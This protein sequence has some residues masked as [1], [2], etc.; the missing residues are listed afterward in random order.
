MQVDQISQLMQ[1]SALQNQTNS[2]ENSSAADSFFSNMFENLIQNIANGQTASTNTN[3]S[4]GVNKTSGI[5]SLSMKA[6]SLQ[7]MLQL[8]ALQSMSSTCDNIGDAYD[9]SDDGTDNSGDSGNL[10][11]SDILQS[12]SGDSSTTNQ[13]GSILDNFI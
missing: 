4:A 12:M 1:L 3:N 10:G 5:D 2:G 9:S 6:Q 13:S 11:Y 8:Q 7:D